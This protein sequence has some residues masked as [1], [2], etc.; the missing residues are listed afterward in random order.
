[1]NSTEFKSLSQEQQRE[2]LLTFQG[3]TDI[4]DYE[5]ILSMRGDALDAKSAECPH[6]NSSNYCKN[7]N[8]KKSRRYKCNDCNRTFTEYTGTWINGIHQKELIPGFLRTME[9]SLSLKNT[10]K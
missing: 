1:M 2:L 9:R 4:N 10:C 8:D 6:C 3:I 5:S 7:G